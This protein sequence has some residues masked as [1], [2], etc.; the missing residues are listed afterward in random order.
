MSLVVVVVVVVVVFVVVFVVVS[1]VLVV[2]S[3]VVV[4]VIDNPTAERAR[5]GICFAVTVVV[6]V[7][8]VVPAYVFV[9]LGTRQTAKA[10]RGGS[11]EAGKAGRTRNGADLVGSRTGRAR[12]TRGFAVVVFVFVAVIVVFEC[13]WGA[14]DAQRGVLTH[15]PSARAHPPRQALL[16]LFLLLLFLLLDVVVVGAAPGRDDA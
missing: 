2:V 11:V 3:L 9:V 8:T 5:R 7:A 1:L 13:P 6:I 16:L 4:V 15:I 12:Q 10:A 14:G